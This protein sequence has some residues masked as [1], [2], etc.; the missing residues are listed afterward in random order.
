MGSL[1][2]T[3]LAFLD[4]FSSI[5]RVHITNNKAENEAIDKDQIILYECLAQIN[6]NDKMLLPI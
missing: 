4:I 2:L 3:V 5:S 1:M 6:A